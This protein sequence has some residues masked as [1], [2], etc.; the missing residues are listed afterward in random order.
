MGADSQLSRYTIPSPCAM[1][2]DEMNGDAPERFCAACGKQ[3]HDLTAMS[4]RE[5]AQVL[6]HADN[7]ICARLYSRADGTLTTSAAE[8]ALSPRIR[9]L[10]FTIR[11]IMAVVAGVAGALGM[12]R[13]FVD[14]ARIAAP[15]PPAPLNTLVM[16]KM[17]PRFYLQSQPANPPAGASPASTSQCSESADVY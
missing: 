17:I 16:G 15:R 4:A 11:S 3:V 12:V 2:W 13:L 6:Q 14:Q 10:Q 9:P 1:N 8:V 5:C 7:A